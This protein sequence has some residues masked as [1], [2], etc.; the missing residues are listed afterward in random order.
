MSTDQPTVGLLRVIGKKLE[1]ALRDKEG[2]PAL[3]FVLMMFDF[4]TIDV[5]YVSNAKR[6]DGIA[7]LEKLLAAMKAEP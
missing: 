7:A 5:A 1:D 2:K 4:D 6:N 3:G